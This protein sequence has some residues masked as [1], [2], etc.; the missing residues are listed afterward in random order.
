[1]LREECCVVT[2]CIDIRDSQG[3]TSRL[4]NERSGVVQGSCVVRTALGV[5][6][7]ASA[8]VIAGRQ[9][10]KKGL[11]AALA[12]LLRPNATGWDL[13]RVEPTWLNYKH[14]HLMQVAALHSLHCT[15]TP[16]LR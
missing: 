4:T 9:H 15:G 13:C 2:F 8:L 16:Y 6:R 1:M 7:D 10:A 5:A 3:A 11:S 14:V 12:H